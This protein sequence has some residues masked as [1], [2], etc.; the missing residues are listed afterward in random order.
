MKVIIAGAALAC[1]ALGA[2]ETMPTAP[3]ANSPPRLSLAE[4]SVVE[5]RLR[6]DI[7]VPVGQPLVPQAVVARDQPLISIPYAYRHTAVLT[8]DVE[9]FSFTVSGVQAPKGSP[10]YYA[11]TFGGAGAFNRGSISDLWC[12]LPKEAGGK[13]DTICLLRNQ[14]SVAAIA[15]TRLNP[16]MWVDQFA[17][18]TGSFDYVKTPIFER[19]TVSIPGDLKL[20]YRHRGWSKD[21]LEVTEFAVG[22]RVQE[23]SFRREADGTAILPTIAGK[24]RVSPAPGGSATVSLEPWPAQP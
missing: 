11:G 19:R 4:M 13:R 17:P 8:E 2:C 5:G 24:L 15:P 10:G 16:W 18:A 9:G 23:L 20:E 1:M 12:F 21:V 22:Q 6:S 14:P 7:A 3:P